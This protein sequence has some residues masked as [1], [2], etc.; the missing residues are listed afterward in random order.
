MSAFPCQDIYGIVS[1]SGAGRRLAMV[2]GQQ[3]SSSLTFYLNNLISQP[4]ELESYKVQLDSILQLTNELSSELEATYSNGQATMIYQ[5]NNI[6]NSQVAPHDVT[7]MLRGY[8]NARQD[9]VVQTLQP[10]G[11][12]L[13]GQNGCCSATTSDLTVIAASTTTLMITTTESTTAHDEQAGKALPTTTTPWDEDKTTTGQTTSTGTTSTASEG[14]TTTVAATTTTQA[15]TMMTTETTT[16]AVMT[17]ET[18]TTAVMTTETTTTAVPEGTTSTTSAEGTTSTASEGTS[19]TGTEADTTSTGSSTK[20]ESEPAPAPGAEDTTSTNAATSTDTTESAD[21]TSTEAAVVSSTS[22]EA[23]TMSSTSTEASIV[24]STST[25]ATSVEYVGVVNGTMKCL[26]DDAAID[27]AII[28]PGFKDAIEKGIANAANTSRPYVDTIYEKQNARRMASSYKRRLQSILLV[29]YTITLPLSHVSIGH[30]QDVWATLKSIN[31][32]ALE[33]T[34]NTQLATLTN[35]TVILLEHIDVWMGV[36]TPTTSTTT[37]TNNQ[38]TT[39]RS[40]IVDEL[41]EDDDSSPDSSAFIP[42]LAVVA[43]FCWDRI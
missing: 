34:V 6:G 21:S 24:S 40:L 33:A 39:T 35:Y 25:E 26:M 9:N 36:V 29:T 23:A 28:D 4:A 22:T 7:E 8:L 38:S 14:T 10:I 5:V 43:M 30:H 31:L 12:V 1:G 13:I 11:A 41:I 19:S 16:T 15:N 2:V 18:T 32:T 42:L 3:Q 17:T 20:G 27:A 37:T